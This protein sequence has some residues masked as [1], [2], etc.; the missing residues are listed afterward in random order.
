MKKVG[1]A[2]FFL[3]VVVGVGLLGFL[4]V[5][6]IQFERN[7]G[8]YLKRAAD[9]NTIALARQELSKAVSYLESENLTTGSTHVIYSTPACDLDFWYTNL[10]ASLTELETTPADADRLTVSNQLL[11]LR[12]TIMDNQKNGTKV[13]QPPNVRLYPDHIEFQ[14]LGLGSLIGL[15]L[16]SI[17]FI[18][19]STKTCQS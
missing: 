19:C 5:S 15:T 2:I 12:E 4:I 9:S 17:S 7:C 13:T 6:R 11:K 16:G 14:M 10:K 18:D 1:I 8:G 3:S